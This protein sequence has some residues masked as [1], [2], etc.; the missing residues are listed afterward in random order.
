MNLHNA[1]VSECFIGSESERPQS[2]ERRESTQ[3]VSSW[4]S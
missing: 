3:K 4:K 1:A 2:A